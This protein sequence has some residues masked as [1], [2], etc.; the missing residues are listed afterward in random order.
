MTQSMEES[1]DEFEGD[2]REAI[3]SALDESIEGAGELIRVDANEWLM[4]HMR[5]VN[6]PG[7]A[8]AS[9]HWPRGARPA[10]A[11][12]CRFHDKRGLYL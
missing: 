6:R 7:I 11:A 5:A 12:S 2:A 10:R 1:H 3:R 9:D 4:T 8:G